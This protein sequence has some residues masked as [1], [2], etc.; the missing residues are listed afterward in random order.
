MF[1]LI[2][3]LQNNSNR[4]EPTLINATIT[5]SSPKVNISCGRIYL[6]EHEILLVY[7]CPRMPRTCKRK[8]GISIEFKDKFLR[9]KIFLIRG[10]QNNA[11]W[12]ESHINQISHW[13]HDT[14]WFTCLVNNMNIHDYIFRDKQNPLILGFYLWKQLQNKW[15]TIFKRILGR[16]VYINLQNICSICVYNCLLN[17][18]KIFNP[19]QEI[20]HLT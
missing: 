6:T 8:M 20:G 2:W 4:L 16:I 17:W 7:I 12:T 13:L 18:H 5:E 3:Q 19:K 15:K 14:I 9:R 1:L 11:T 10:E